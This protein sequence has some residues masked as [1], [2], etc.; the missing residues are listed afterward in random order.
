MNSP[1]PAEAPPPT[2]LQ[3]ALQE[4][5]VRLQFTVGQTETTVAQLQTLQPGYTF[6]LETL[7]ETPVTIRANGKAIGRGELLQVG[8]RIGVRITEVSSHGV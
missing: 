6:E 5:Q 8:E 4:A 3:Q 2:A 7:A 1:A